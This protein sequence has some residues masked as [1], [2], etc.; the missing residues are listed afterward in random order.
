MSE[1]PRAIEA[2]LAELTDAL[3]AHAA[4]MI[5]NGEP[6]EV[7]PAINGL[8]SAAL[9]YVEVVGEQTGWGNV[10]DSLYA[11]APLVRRLGHRLSRR[12]RL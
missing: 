1:E 8:R 12:K 2:R 11:D 5:S 6:M 9:A 7:M 4:A 10:F 3:R